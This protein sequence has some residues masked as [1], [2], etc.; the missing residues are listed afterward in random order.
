MQGERSTTMT[1][2]QTSTLVIKDQAGSYFL[3]PQETLERGRVP[4]E[5]AAEVEQLLAAATQG[6]EERDDVHGHHPV[7]I[8]IAVAC[9]LYTGFDLGYGLAKA[10]LGPQAEV[11]DISQVL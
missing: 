9:I 11:I 5:R 6:A 10:A 2:A 7:A 8:G 1:N 3:L 4:E